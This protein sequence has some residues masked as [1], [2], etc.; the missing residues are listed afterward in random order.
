MEEQILEVLRQHPMGLRLREIGGYLGT[1]HI[2]LVEPLHNLLQEGKVCFH[3]V[4]DPAN[5]E[6]YDIW[7]IIS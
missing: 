7:K 3:S 5:M 4:S 6:W 2:N 1:W